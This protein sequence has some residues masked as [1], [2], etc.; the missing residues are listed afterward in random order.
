MRIGPLAAAVAAGACVLAFVVVLLTVLP[1]SA[2]VWVGL[3]TVVALCLGY[4][5]VAGACVRGLGAL[6]DLGLG[7]FGMVGLALAALGVMLSA[8]S[9]RLPAPTAAVLGLL[10]LAY[11]VLVELAQSLAGE[12]GW[13]PEGTRAAGSGAS[14][15]CLAGWVRTVAP[16][17]AAGLAGAVVLSVVVVLPLPPAAWLVVT[18]PA[19]LA[20]AVVLVLPRH[21]RR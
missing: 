1:P 16:L 10:A 19:I 5:G 4:A 20:V 14:T 9:G 2:L 13:Q 15:A 3:P 17:L 7:A 6:A 11:L 12:D 21:S 18:A 8:D